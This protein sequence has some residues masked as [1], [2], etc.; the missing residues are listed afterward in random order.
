LPYQTTIQSN[1]FEAVVMCNP[2]TASE[3]G[4]TVAKSPLGEEQTK[5]TFVQKLG[6]LHV[7]RRLSN[8]VGD[9]DLDT[10]TAPLKPGGPEGLKL[11]IFF[12]R[13]V[14]E[15][16]ANDYLCLTSRIYP[17]RDD[18]LGVEFFAAGGDAIITSVDIW[19]IKSIW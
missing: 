4:L 11:H 9:V 12:D 6:Q 1:Q 14:I 17:T 10:Q 8:A 2:G 5:I 16:F 3:V 13:S 7:E 19:E 15:V 18:S